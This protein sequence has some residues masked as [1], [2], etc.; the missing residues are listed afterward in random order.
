MPELNPEALD[1][2]SPRRVEEGDGLVIIGPIDVSSVEDSDEALEN[3]VCDCGREQMEE[4]K[5]R[6]TRSKKVPRSHYE[7]HF[8]RCGQC[9]K[10]KILLLDVTAR[11]RIDGV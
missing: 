9:G 1:Y 4:Y 10:E 2:E 3:V 8:F 5:V 11:R 6:K 7:R